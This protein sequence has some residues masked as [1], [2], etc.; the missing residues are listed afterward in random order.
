MKFQLVW[1]DRDGGIALHRDGCRD[2]AKVQAMTG[3]AV[4]TL[5]GDD[6]RRVFVDALHENFSEYDRA[7]V[8]TWIDGPARIM[9]CVK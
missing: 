5:E 3:C 2:V 7:H 6:P 9:P 4:E 1:Q 8:E